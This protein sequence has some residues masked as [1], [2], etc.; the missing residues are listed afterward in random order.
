MRL[1]TSAGKRVVA[2]IHHDW[3]RLHLREL[4]AAVRKSLP[5]TAGL[6]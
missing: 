5:A 1:S 2:S 3:T 6:A 4:A